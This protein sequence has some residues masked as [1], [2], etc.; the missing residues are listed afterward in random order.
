MFGENVMVDVCRVRQGKIYSYDAESFSLDNIKYIGDYAYGLRE[1][2]ILL[3]KITIYNNNKFLIGGEKKEVIGRL[4]KC[5]AR[6]L[7]TFDNVK[8][9]AFLFATVYLGQDMKQVV[10]WI[11]SNGKSEMYF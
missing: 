3:V 2:E 5:R 1:D 8:L 6:M 9:L 7:A 10:D 4:D 11:M